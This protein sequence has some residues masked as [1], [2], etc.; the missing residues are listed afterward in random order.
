MRARR[1][2]G[3]VA[4]SLVLRAVAALAACGGGSGEGTIEGS[5]VAGITDVCQPL[6]RAKSYRYT[7]SYK[8]ESLKPTGPVDERAVGS[9]PFALRPGDADF[10]VAQELQGAVRNPDRVEL[11]INTEGTDSLRMIFI[12]PNQ[13]VLTGDQWIQRRAG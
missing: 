9:P 4:A 13:Y 12:G 11:T 7:F 8:L 5:P 1:W 2:S 3:T 10:Q 6:A